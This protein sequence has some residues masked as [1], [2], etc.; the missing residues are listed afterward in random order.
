MTYGRPSVKY[1]TVSHH[2]GSLHPEVRTPVYRSPRH[3]G[4]AGSLRM[5]RERSGAYRPSKREDVTDRS[6]DRPRPGALMQRFRDAIR[7]RHCSRRTEQ[8]Y[9]Y[10]IRRFIHH[11]GVRHPD[12][13]GEPEIND[14]P[15]HLAVRECVSASTQKQALSALLFLYRPVPGREVGDLGEVI[16]A[17]KPRR[18]PVVMTREEVKAV[19]ANM[20][21]EKRLMASLMYGAG[22]GCQSGLGEKSDMPHLPAFICHSFTRERLRHPDSSG[23][24]GTQ[25]CAN[26]ND[27]HAPSQQGS[28][29]C[30]QS[31]GWAVRMWPYVDPHNMTDETTSTEIH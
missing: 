28:C 6:N 12:E 22:G 3:A 8:A 29:R 7:A 9:A 31:G 25:G 30:S 2:T 26:D 24:A 15:T 1:R 23:A 10:W 20:T 18:L 4:A 11:H 14:F 13:M 16:R 19:L 27:L 17:R 5:L 21:G